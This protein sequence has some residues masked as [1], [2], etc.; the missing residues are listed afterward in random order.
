M[1]KELK[2]C[3]PR[4]CICDL[5]WFC[6]FEQLL[7]W[8]PVFVVVEHDLAVWTTIEVRVVP[9][10]NVRVVR[11]GRGSQTPKLFSNQ[12]LLFIRQKNRA[13]NFILE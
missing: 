6:V 7:L 2:A 4:V 13:M 3:P 12:N 8:N 5:T 10:Q 11:V 9:S 1:W